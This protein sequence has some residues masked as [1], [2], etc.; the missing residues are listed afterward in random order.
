MPSS[1]SERAL[2]GESLTLDTE[3]VERARQALQ[4]AFE[5]GYR[6]HYCAEWTED[7]GC[8]ICWSIAGDILRAA[9]GLQCCSL[10]NGTGRPGP[11][12]DACSECGGN[13][14]EILP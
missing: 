5:F 13:G 4:D 12:G 7:D 9:E 6:S 10:C 11:E 3:A 1:R 14:L 2:E 8:T